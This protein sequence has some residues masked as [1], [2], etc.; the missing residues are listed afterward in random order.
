LT[1]EHD[2]STARVILRYWRPEEVDRFLDLYSRWEVARW[3]GATPTPLRERSEAVARIERW[4]GLNEEAAR[5]GTREG[6]W[7]VERRSDGVVAGTVILV[8]LPDGEGELEV[9][10]H[11]HPDSWRQGYA[12]ESARCVLD[13]AFA[14]GVDE[15][16]AVVRPD[17]AASL[18]V[19]RR[20]GMTSLGRTTRYYDSELELF[21]LGA[22]AYA[23]RPSGR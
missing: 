6:R 21:R 5:T 14:G 7:A 3:L 8:R 13:G 20:L 1:A 19:C 16:F 2:L 18:A 4:A 11:L 22:D 12:T 10:W 17:N 23:A 15:V 9:G